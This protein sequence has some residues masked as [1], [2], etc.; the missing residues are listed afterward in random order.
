MNL[1]VKLVNI[2][3]ETKGT[4]FIDTFYILTHRNA[5]KWDVVSVISDYRNIASIVVY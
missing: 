4:D 1:Y 2:T 3:F 5:F